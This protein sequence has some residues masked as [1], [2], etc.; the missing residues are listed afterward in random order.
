MIVL[1]GGKTEFHSHNHVSPSQW[2]SNTMIC[3]G[4][5]MIYDLTVMHMFHKWLFHIIN[6]SLRMKIR[7]KSSFALICSD[8]Q[9]CSCSFVRFMGPTLGLPGSCWPQMGPMLAPLTLLSGLVTG[10]F[11]MKRSSNTGL[12][13]LLYCLSDQCLE[14]TGEY[15]RFGMPW[16][17]CDIIV[18]FSS[19][20]PVNTAIFRAYWKNQLWGLVS[21]TFCL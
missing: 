14:Q 11:P 12:S 8:S 15:Q 21:T 20:P 5:E 10:A 1:W 16:T 19:L 7:V 6:V 3:W 18:V 2:L 13:W 9:I 17:S 4:L